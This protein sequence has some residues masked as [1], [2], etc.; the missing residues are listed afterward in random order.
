MRRYTIV[1]MIILL[2]TVTTG[3]LGA[4]KGEGMTLNAQGLNIGASQEERDRLTWER[5]QAEIAN[6][7]ARTQ[8]EIE[9]ERART[10]ATI[11]QSRQTGKVWRVVLL[12]LGVTSAVALL[13]LGAGYAG[14]AMTPMAAQGVEALRTA[15]EIRKVKRLEVNLEIG[16]EGY[17]GHLLAEGYTDEEIA[18]IVR[19]AP[20]LDAPRLQ[21][22]QA[23]VG[24]R[25]VKALA[26]AGELNEIL[27][28]LPERV[29]KK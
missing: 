7:T 20:A 4:D 5:T 28:R 17:S 15:L 22:L 21:Q 6:E 14:K 29:E 2:A 19:K 3:C 16:P 12:A 27:A 18:K 25:G 8:A 10:E 1:I 13:V 26:D 24:P 9:N 11:E 23:R